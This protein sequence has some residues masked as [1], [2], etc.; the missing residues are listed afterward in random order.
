MAVECEESARLCQRMAICSSFACPTS[1][2]LMESAA[3]TYPAVA[4]GLPIMSGRKMPVV[5]VGSTSSSPISMQK[6]ELWDST[7]WK[8]RMISMVFCQDMQWALADYSM[9][10]LGSSWVLYPEFMRSMKPS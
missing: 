6:E 7:Q 1:G 3:H 10:M 9:V 4:W 5:A 2:Q 8:M